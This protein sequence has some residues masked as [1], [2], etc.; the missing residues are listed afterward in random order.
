MKAIRVAAYGGLDAMTLA[1][2]DDPVPGDDE[3]LIDVAAAAVN[4]ID[5]KIVSGAMKAFIPL[6]L[7]FTPGVDAA[8]TVL[9]VGRNVSTLAPGDEV[10]G[11]IG[12]VGAYASRIVVDPARLARKPARLSFTNAAATPAATLTAWQALHEHGELRKGQS[13]LIHA[14]AGGVGSAAVQLAKL[15][16]AHV[17]GTASAGNREYVQSLGAAEVID[18]HATDFAK[19]VSDVDLVLDLVGGTTQARSW[20]VLKRGGILVST[21]SKPDTQRGNEAQATGKHFA[22]RSDGP[23]LAA[24]GALHASGDLR[25]HIDSV[26]SLPE[27]RH[28][29]ARSMSGHVRGKVV[30]DMAA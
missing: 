8:G 10:M 9:A 13:V 16:G 17:I 14:A 27:A 28:A 1:K 15:A 2:L 23:Q 6:P 21:V 11:F 7:P 19:R 18:Y 29:L 4:P 5:W 22:T 12:I 30:L 25:I 24:L 20:S 26:F 3:V